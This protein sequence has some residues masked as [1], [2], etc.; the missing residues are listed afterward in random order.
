MNQIIKSLKW[1]AIER[2]ATQL[3]QLVVMLILAKML[4]P[5]AFGL[6]GIL[7]IFIA[8]SQVLVDSG[9]NSA[10]I[11][12]TNRKE[13]DFSTAFIFNILISLICY[14]ILFS[15]APFIAVYFH[16]PELTNLTRILS[17]II[18]INSFSMIQKTKLT[19]TL[20]F[21]TQ[22]IASLLSAIISGLTALIAAYLNYGVWSL[23]L[24]SII[25]SLFSVLFLN[26]LSPWKP[27]LKFSL[28]SFRDLFSFGSKIMISGLIDCVYQNI[29]QVII[30]KKFTTIDVGYFTQANQ[31]VRTPSITITSIIQRVT[32]PILSSIQDNEKSL[33]ENYILTL[34]LSAAI[35]FPLLCGLGAI[36]DPIIPLFLGNEWLPSAT[37]VSILTMGLLLYPIHAINLNFLQ[38]KGRSDL[39]LKLE[40]IKKIITT[41]ILIVSIPYGI[42][43]ICFGI[44]IQSYIALFINTYYSGKLGNLST[45]SQLKMHIP[46][47]LLSILSCL[48]AKILSILITT[49]LWNELVFTILIAPILY[50]IAI[51]YI[52]T[53]LYHYIISSITSK[54]LIK[55]NE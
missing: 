1:S 35:V 37:L 25:F 38:V 48:V 13:I 9:L 23:V 51:K 29:Y 47:W 12:K 17:L 46:L 5:E 3:V 24:Q 45:I 32:Y 52:Q 53:D 44:M 41:L 31:L 27:S 6:M 28:Y 34:R 50:I 54:K 15:I 8:I 4:G 20:D 43:A 36:A 18:I 10:I 33:N 14:I 11:R 49:N 7:A 26:I 42:K 16:Q 39:Y 30:G 2:L 55:K 22:A 19:I 21:K 40:I